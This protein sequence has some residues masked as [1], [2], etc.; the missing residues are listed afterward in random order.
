[1]HGGASLQELVVPVIEYSR[2]REDSSEKVK[3]RLM[4]FDERISSGYLK[5]NVLQLEP[6]STGLKEM[7][8]V[9]GLYTEQEE[10]ISNE[11]RILVNSVATNPLERNTEIVLTL[12]SKGS[13]LSQCILK[14]Y[15]VEDEQRL[16]PLF[17]QR[18]IIQSLIQRDEFI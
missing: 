2:M 18:I 10:L 14:A 12:S 7:D 16:N 15:D 5:L 8:A 3:L 17:N 6:V 11:Y 4:K 9:V 1:M 13:K